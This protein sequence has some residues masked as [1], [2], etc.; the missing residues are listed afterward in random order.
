MT[1]VPFFIETT[2]QSNEMG[3]RFICRHISGFG[4]CTETKQ[5][6]RRDQRERRDLRVTYRGLRELEGRSNPCVVSIKEELTSQSNE[7]GRRFI[8]RHISGFGDC[9]ETKQ[10][11]RR[12]QREAGHGK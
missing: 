3:R 12:D 2:S 1:E 9:T 4:D 7:M 5:R 6:S 10:R 8:C 11:S